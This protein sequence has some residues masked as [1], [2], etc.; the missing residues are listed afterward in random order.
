M[1]GGDI[2]S[3]KIKLDFSVSINPLGA[4][5]NVKRAVAEAL[6]AD[7]SIIEQYPDQK[8]RKLAAAL[9]DKLKLP[10]SQ[11]LFG[12]GAS[13]LIPALFRA[14]KVRRGLLLAPCF[15]GYERA[16]KSLRECGICIEYSF[17]TLSQRSKFQLDEKQLEELAKCVEAEFRG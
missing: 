16:F 2:Y 17:F 7:S 10:E 15:S 9:S 6:K 5:G 1:Y 4:S 11:I 14:L 12:N 8:C 13:E 3:N